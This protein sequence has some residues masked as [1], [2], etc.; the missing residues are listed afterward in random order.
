MVGSSSKVGGRAKPSY[1]NWQRKRTQNPSS[2]GSNPT[3]GT[4]SAEALVQLDGVSEFARLPHH[5]SCPHT[6]PTVSDSLS[7][8]AV[9]SSSNKSA[10]TSSVIVALACRASAESPSRW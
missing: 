6:W 4:Q 1:P 9:K 10:Y 7:A 3:E 2:V 5:P 8:T